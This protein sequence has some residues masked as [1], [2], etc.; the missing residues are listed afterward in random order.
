MNFNKYITGISL[1]VLVTL[2][3]SAAVS[4]LKQKEEEYVFSPR[5]TRHTMKLRGYLDSYNSRSPVGTASWEIAFNPQ[6]EMVMENI[7]DTTLISPNIWINEEGL[8]YDWF[9]FE[10]CILKKCKTEREKAL[11]IFYYWI[12]KRMH[13]T[14]RDPINHDPFV[15]HNC[16][17]G[18]LCFNDSEI[19]RRLYGWAGFKTAKGMVYG[20]SVRN[21]Y[22]DNKWN[23]VDTD[24]ETLCLA[25]DNKT[26]LST[27]EMARD[28]DLIRRSHASSL[29]TIRELFTQELYASCFGDERIDKPDLAIEKP[30]E[31][32]WYLRPGEKLVWKWN[33]AEIVFRREVLEQSTVWART[34]GLLA[35]GFIYYEPLV[36]ANLLSRQG[37]TN[38]QA[39]TEM[40]K[41]VIRKGGFVKINTRIPF[42]ILNCKLALHISTG[43]RLTVIFAFDDKKELK[44]FTVA[45]GKIELDIFEYY[46]P[47][48]EKATAK[49][50]LT[51]TLDARNASSDI[52]IDTLGL[53]TI[54][55]TSRLAM[56]GL[57]RG[58]N[59]LQFRCKNKEGDYKVRVAHLWQETKENRPPKPPTKPIYPPNKDRINN[60]DV[61]FRWRAAREPNGDKVV[62]YL[63][64]VSDRKDMR[65]PASPVF[66]QFAPD[67]HNKEEAEPVWCPPR[68]GLLTPDKRYY[69]RV[70]AQDE[71]GA[72]S[73]WSKVWWFI[74]Q[75][76]FAPVNLRYEVKGR[77]VYLSWRPSSE[78]SRPVK[79]EIYG[80]DERGFS[81]YGEARKITGGFHREKWYKWDGYELHSQ[82]NLFCET[83][84]TKIK[85]ASEKLIGKQGAN[86]CYYRVIAVDAEGAR[87][88]SS[89]FIELPHPFIIEP[90]E[91]HYMPGEKIRR[92]MHVITSLGKLL[93]HDTKQAQYHLNYWDHEEIQF[94]L[95]QAPAWLR[96]SNSD[97]YL[98]GRVPPDASGEYSFS[99]AVRNQ[100]RNEDKVT[101]KLIPRKG[102]DVEGTGG[103][104]DN[105]E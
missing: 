69:W 82:P 18:T 27:A 95:E 93:A 87:S 75:G 13:S 88:D 52:T 66:Y 28:H 63:L 83:T 14:T 39:E 57:K 92:K 101:L 16:L 105:N 12:D 8:L 49:R 1:F 21:V 86:R 54:F 29:W 26:L 37:I 65:F 94:E 34:L 61:E 74:P 46:D 90:Q 100:N 6:L 4:S 77:E 19:V 24:V 40:G 43:D 5:N 84:E 15:V 62:K 47:E 33:K 78:G 104:E 2:A 11:A 85:V 73:D 20:H 32:I 51:I 98:V 55:Q 41:L 99:L 7:G 89:D 96:V 45:E 31:L 79:Y 38:Q 10:E 56:P 91:I 44:K 80:S 64:Q 3:S 58:K 59:N 76:S 42:I 70:K 103:M 53:K 25:K 102:E 9:D 72:W 68:S 35:N 22:F 36:D 23:M 67:P 81:C 71:R 30:R 48:Q 60:L 97:G 17:A 50:S